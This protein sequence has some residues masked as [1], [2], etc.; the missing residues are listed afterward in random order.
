MS[1]IK[2]KNEEI[3]SKQKRYIV[4]FKIFQKRIRAL[5]DR[6]NKR[7]GGILNALAI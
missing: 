5:L 6:L 7:E 2:R 4:S 3:T 1:E